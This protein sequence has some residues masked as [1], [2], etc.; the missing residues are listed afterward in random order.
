[1]TN[2]KILT[3][4]DFA[5]RGILASSFKLLKV[6]PMLGFTLSLLSLL[7]LVIIVVQALFF[8]CSFS[9]SGSCSSSWE[10]S[11]STWA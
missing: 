3:T 4:A 5:Y 7:A 10:S 2:F 9:C 8:G 1:V 6:F 11:A